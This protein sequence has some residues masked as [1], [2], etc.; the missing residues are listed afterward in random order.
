MTLTNARREHINKLAKSELPQV[1]VFCGACHSTALMGWTG[2]PA[3][4][5]LLLILLHNTTPATPPATACYCL[6]LL[7]LLP[8]SSPALHSLS[9]ETSYLTPDQKLQIW[10][11]WLRRISGQHQLQSLYMS[12]LVPRWNQFESVI[13]ADHPCT[14]CT[15]FAPGFWM[16]FSCLWIVKH[17]HYI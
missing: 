9:P 3:S 8:I 5:L 14:L 15:W 11:I 7:L 1:A 17:L 2:S 6:L 4:Y 16:A 12:A 10:F 13:Q